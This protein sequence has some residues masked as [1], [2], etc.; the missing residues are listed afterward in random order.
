MVEWKFFMML[1]QKKMIWKDS[2]EMYYPKGL[3]DPD[4]CVVKFDARR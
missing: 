4:Y 2:D 1:N 3:T